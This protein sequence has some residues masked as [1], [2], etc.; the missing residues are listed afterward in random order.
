MGE[1]AAAAGQ[2]RVAVEAS[3][4]HVEGR[5][6]GD[7]GGHLVQLLL[8]FERKQ[9]HVQTAVFHTLGVL[10]AEESGPPGCAG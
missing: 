7:L 5:G 3:G 10:A 1:V 4:D 6:G 9:Q 8:A 2:H